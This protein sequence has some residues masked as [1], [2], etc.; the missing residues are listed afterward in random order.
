M[1]EETAVITAVGL[2]AYIGHDRTKDQSTEHKRYDESFYPFGNELPVRTLLQRIPG[3]Y[4]CQKEHYGHIER[5][6]ENNETAYDLVGT[7][8]KIIQLSPGVKCLCGMIRDQQQYDQASDVIDIM[9][10]H[11]LYFKLR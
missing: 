11:V 9:F 8:K 2:I 3:T 10:S 5:T 7:K 6:A 1:R 4:S